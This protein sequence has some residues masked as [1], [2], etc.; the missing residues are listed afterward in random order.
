VP[1]EFGEIGLY[2]SVGR[3][4]KPL[5]SR[6]NSDSAQSYSPTRDGKAEIPSGYN[7]RDNTSFSPVRPGASV[8]FSVPR[9][10][11]AREL[12]IRIAFYYGWERSVDVAT[13]REPEHLVSFS[14]SSLKD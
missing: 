13:G 11:L 4:P 6:I 2:Y 8:L 10:H 7:T 12:F 3:V 14:S 1:T 5:S 9:E